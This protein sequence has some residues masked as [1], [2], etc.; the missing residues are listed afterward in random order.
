[1]LVEEFRGVYG[2]GI[3]M[4]GF[5]CAEFELLMQLQLIQGRAHRTAQSVWIH[6]YPDKATL[7]RAILA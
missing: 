3:L 6:Q 1:M 4:M 7:P 5:G 2:T